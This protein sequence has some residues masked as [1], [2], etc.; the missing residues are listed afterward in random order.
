MPVGGAASRFKQHSRL[1]E[2]AAG[3]RLGILNTKMPGRS[4]VKLNNSIS[5]LPQAIA[6]QHAGAGRA[7]LPKK[8]V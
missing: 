8:P 5:S 1:N 4:S 2:A 6:V 3:L 7:S